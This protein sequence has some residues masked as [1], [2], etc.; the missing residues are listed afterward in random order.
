MVASLSFVGLRC[1]QLGAE[2]THDPNTVRLLA[3]K[4]KK[5]KKKDSWPQSSAD[6]DWP[7]QLRAAL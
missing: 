6:A 7:N 1:D 3:T 4:K 5:K 2:M